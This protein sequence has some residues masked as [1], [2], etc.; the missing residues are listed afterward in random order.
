MQGRNLTPVIQELCCGSQ[1]MVFLSGP[2]QVGKTTL[3]KSLASSYAQ[4]L[5]VNWDNP[6]NRRTWVRSPSMFL[7][8]FDQ[9]R[10]A[11][12][13]FDEIHKS[14]DWRTRLKGLWDEKAFPLDVV[15]TGSSRLNTLRKAGDSL[16]GRYYHFHLHP[17]TLGELAGA[18]GIGSENTMGRIR[19][20]DLPTKKSDALL[21]LDRWSGFPEPFLKASV[22]SHRLWQRTRLERLI[23]EDLRD[24]SRL[25]DLG[26][27][28]MLASLLPEKIGS[29]LSVQSLREDME[30]SFDTVKRWLRHLEGVYY[31]FQIRPFARK[32]KR[33]LKKEPKVYLYDWSEVK[34]EGA[35]F[36]NLVA[37]HLLKAAQFWTDSGEGLFELFFL[38]DKEKREIDFLLTRE[39]KPWLAV[40]AKLSPTE[41]AE[42][43]KKLL[44]Q[45][46]CPFVQVHKT[47]DAFRK[48]KDDSCEIWLAPAN[49]F[50]AALP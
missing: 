11:L 1:K 27:V 48:V 21:E 7:S 23:R 25:P 22:R 6:E 9:S 20:G 10:E 26:Q 45:V 19:S 50:L 3:A 28:E 17:F 34:D 36:E 46:K 18:A 29:L 24:L 40:E 32:I 14:K 39:K 31:H 35:R 13:I 47:G 30:V 16:L 4:S 49:R 33:T 42:S 12:L 44:R 41:P 15:V 8:G 38:R 43:A 2:R 5:Y 37:G